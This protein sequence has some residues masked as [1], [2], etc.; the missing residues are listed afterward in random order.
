M[1]NFLAE[2]EVKLGEVVQTTKIEGVTVVPGGPIPPNPS[3]L[4]ASPRMA[5]LLEQAKEL[6]DIV[7]VDSPPVLVVADGPIL[8]SQV[9]G[10]IMVVDGFSTRSSALR[11]ALDALRATDVNIVGAI[12][13]KL[14]RTRFA[15]TYSYPRYYDYYYYKY[16]RSPEQDATAAN[17]AGPL[18]KRPV[19]WVRSVLS[20]SRHPR[21]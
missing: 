1:S 21:G 15:Y 4:L 10:A 11:A 7:L 19:G 18:L 20:R 8:A 17:G 12:I 2:Q 14:K 3:E 6:A 9:D 16:Y 5:A 13:N